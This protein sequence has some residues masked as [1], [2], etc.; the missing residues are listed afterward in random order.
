MA[1]PQFLR[2]F[3]QTRRTVPTRQLSYTAHKAPRNCNWYA[4]V[5]WTTTKLPVTLGYYTIRNGGLVTET[6]H[7][8]TNLVR[9]MTH[10]S[11]SG[12]LAHCQTVWA[13]RNPPLR[14]STRQPTGV[15]PA[16][17]RVTPPQQALTHTHRQQCSDSSEPD[18]TQ[19]WRREVGSPARFLSLV[20]DFLPHKESFATSINERWL[21]LLPGMSPL[22]SSSRS[23]VAVTWSFITVITN[24][25]HR[26]IHWAS[27]IYCTPSKLHVSLLQGKPFCSNEKIH[28]KRNPIWKVRWTQSG[29]YVVF[30][31]AV[32]SES[33][34]ILGGVGVENVPTRTPT[35]M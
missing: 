5:K 31:R 4:L 30:I 11:D 13:W 16:V 27:S 7:Y 23:S 15:N 20:K 24:S 8:C 10:T 14:H 2:A 17:R 6:I 32:E 25:H 12:L 28:Q 29:I 19:Q 21:I 3:L 18:I 33:E 35:S 22:C 1:I 34:R 26:A 9:G